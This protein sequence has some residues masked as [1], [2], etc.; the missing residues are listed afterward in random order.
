VKAVII[1]S[2]LVLA[3]CGMPGTHYGYFES[4]LYDASAV[5]A[6]TVERKLS[7]C[8]KATTNAA[9]EISKAGNRRGVRYVVTCD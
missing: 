9:V 6:K 3:A 2:L 5:H 8:R 1:A 7:G 4:D